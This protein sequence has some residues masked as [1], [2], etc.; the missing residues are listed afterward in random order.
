MADSLAKADKK[1]IDSLFKAD[2]E[3]FKAD[4]LHKANAKR[5]RILQAF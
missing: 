5:K 4:S 1:R 3:K 2:K